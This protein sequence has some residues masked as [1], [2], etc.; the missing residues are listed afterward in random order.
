MV[1]I[2]I[3]S[4]LIGWIIAD[5]RGLKQEIQWGLACFFFPP[6]IIGALLWRKPKP[7]NSTGENVTGENNSLLPSP[8]NRG[9]Q[10]RRGALIFLGVIFAVFAVVALIKDNEENSFAC[11]NSGVVRAMVTETKKT[12]L[13]DYIK[14]AAYELN[15][16]R[17]WGPNSLQML[18]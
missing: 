5:R 18:P 2:A 4:G 8:I 16:E 10:M 7:A 11:N 1:I 17:Y 14:T 12:A 15:S 13:Q 9:K 6:A 3:I